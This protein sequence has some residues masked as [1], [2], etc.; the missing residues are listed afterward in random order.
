MSR[1]TD[2]RA[3]KCFFGGLKTIRSTVKKIVLL[4]VPQKFIGTQKLQNILN[5]IKQVIP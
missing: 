5:Q 2:K 3:A 1:C 4:Y